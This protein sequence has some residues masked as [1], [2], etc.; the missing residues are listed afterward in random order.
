MNSDT[1]KNAFD[2][3][4]LGSITLD[5]F[6]KP[7]ETRI[8]HCSETSVDKF[9]YEVGE[10]VRIQTIAKHV[11]GGSANTSVG[12]AQ[13]G[14]KVSAYGT[15]G[16][17]PH[18]EFVIHQLEKKNVDVAKIKV[19]KKYPTSY[20][21]IF[22]FENG[23]RTVFNEKVHPLKFGRFNGTR[24]IY[25]GHVT[26]EEAEAFDRVIDWKQKYPEKIFAWN[27]GKTQFK[28]GMK[29][30]EKLLSYTDLLIVNV[31]EAELFVGEQAPRIPRQKF[32][33]Q[34]LFPARGCSTLIADCRALA[35][36]IL[37]TGVKHLIITDGKHGAQYFSKRESV[38]VPMLTCKKP[39]STLGAGDSFAVGAVTA[40]LENGDDM[41]KNMLIYGSVNAGSVVMNFGAQNG[42]LTRKGLRKECEN[43]Q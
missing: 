16:S 30:F 4:T 1:P 33:G 29:Y 38:F 43:L 10:K 31:E 37:A 35:A 5:T 21:I 34:T 23:R 28:K 6:V 18:G 40:L 39:V 17:D 24:A 27:P 19:Q 9:W 15:I 42:L 8:T 3:I 32:V 41:A 14:L 7:N 20:S 36:T 25:A 22:M 2:I 12:F 11:G 26:E 13:M